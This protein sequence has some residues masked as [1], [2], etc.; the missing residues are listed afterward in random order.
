MKRSNYY[1]QTVAT[2]PKDEQSVNAKLLVQAGFV[3]KLSAGI[4]SLLPLGFKVLK[5]IENIIRDEME[6]VG[7]Q[8]LFLPSMHPAK[9]WEKTGRLTSYEDI[10]KLKEGDREFVLGPTHE[11]VIVPLAK[12]FI[13]S[14]RDLPLALFQFQN[15]FRKELRAKSGLMRGREFLM[16]DLY[17][18]HGNEKDLDV[19]YDKMTESYQNIFRRIGL[20]EKT[21][22]TFAS[23]GSFSRYSHE[24]QTLTEAGEDLI[25]IC[26]KCNL[27]VNKEILDDLKHACPKC[28]NKNL[29]EEKAVEVGNIFK[30]NTKYS[31]PFDLSFVDP[32]GEKKTVIMGCYGI[33]LQRLIGTLAEVFSDEKGLV[34][35]KSVAPFQAC[36]ISLGVEKD[37]KVNKTTESLYEDLTKAGIEILYDDRAVS[38]GEKFSDADLIGLPM[39]IVVSPKTLANNSIEIKARTEK[40]SALIDR[41]KAIKTIVSMLK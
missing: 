13:R 36:L 26:D 21:F 28:G 35:P 18:F 22:L 19:F 15:K 33:G 8:E 9:N 38:P 27:A 29:R 17:S 41:E 10:Y 7:G 24:F 2:A 34:W 16:K 25:Y 4:Y 40:D 23:G 6:K 30:L 5:K 14:Y 31:A 11:E 1:L 20:S 3:N 12:S 39:R 37:E 32:K